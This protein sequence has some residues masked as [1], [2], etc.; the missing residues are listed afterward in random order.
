M[1]TVWKFFINGNVRNFN[2]QSIIQIL[3][4]L[5]VICKLPYKHIFV[6]ILRKLH[7][8]EVYQSGYIS[9]I[10]L[11][12]SRNV[13]LGNCKWTYLSQYFKN[14][15]GHM[16]LYHLFRDQNFAKRSVF[17]PDAF[18]RCITFLLSTSR[19]Y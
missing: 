11:C 3:W 12:L 4:L 10:G 19:K 14:R 17:R 6:F 9:N 15:I 2:M 8:S 16:V 13:S 18:I 5:C 7:I 1:G